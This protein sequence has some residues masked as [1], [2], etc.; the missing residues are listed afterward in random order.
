MRADPNNPDVIHGT[1]CKTS[2]KRQGG[3]TAASH[4]R[5]D[6]THD[7]DVAS[8]LR[9]AKAKVNFLADSN[10]PAHLCCIR[11]TGINS[12]FTRMNS[13]V[14]SFW[15]TVELESD[16]WYRVMGSLCDVVGIAQK[17]RERKEVRSQQKE[18]AN[19][20]RLCRLSQAEADELVATANSVACANCFRAR[21]RPTK[22][23]FRSPL[24]PPWLIFIT[25]SNDVPLRHIKR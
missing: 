25:H 12:C 17:F 5:A 11:G 18:G 21:D 7:E 22:P 2:C 8:M 13:I 19:V 1:W 23:N 24:E 6:F 20:A 3:V 15:P 14:M 16:E 9:Y 4:K 10:S